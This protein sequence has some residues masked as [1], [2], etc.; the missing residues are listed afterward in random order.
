MIVGETYHTS[1][2]RLAIV[3]HN[4]IDLSD[5]QSFFSNGCRDQDV[6]ISFVKVNNDLLACVIKQTFRIWPCLSMLQ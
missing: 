2:R 6:M 4:K 5:I 3:T 1:G